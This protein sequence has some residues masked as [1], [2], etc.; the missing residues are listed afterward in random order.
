MRVSTAR[1][2]WFS[3]IHSYRL[4]LHADQWSVTGASG[5]QMRAQA[6]TSNT[7]GVGVTKILIADDHEVVRSGLRALLSEQPNWQVV[8]E[9]A[10]G[11]EAVAQAVKTAPHVAIVDYSLPVLN[12]LEVTRQIRQ[13]SPGTEVIIFTMHDN[14]SLIHDLL[15]AG[16]LGY[17]LKSDAHRLLLAAVETVAEHKPFFTGMVSETLRQAFL[18][19][20]ND[21]PLTARER[22]VLQLIAEGHTSKEIASILKLSS[23]TVDTPPGGHP[24]QAEYPFDGRPS[25]VRHPQQ[26]DRSIIADWKGELACRLTGASL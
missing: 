4:A 10:D 19:K 9:A 5:I 16:A 12:G 22:S 6:G 7:P 21:G 15:Q 26:N 11:K 8:A 14:N 25:P 3:L 17:V 1:L 24:P 20:G 2:C 23:K 18:T 13:R